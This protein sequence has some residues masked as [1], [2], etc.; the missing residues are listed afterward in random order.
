MRLL[1][2]T[3]TLLWFQTDDP[4]LSHPAKVAFE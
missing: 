2:D 4:Q 3:H 1:P